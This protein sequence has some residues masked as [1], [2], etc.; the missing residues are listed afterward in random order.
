VARIAEAAGLRLV[1]LHGGEPVETVL[2]LLARG[3]RVI[4]A[5]KTT[6]PALLREAEALPAGVGI[7][8]ECG[9]G[10]LPG[11]NAAGWD[12][13]SARPLG[14]RRPFALAGGLTPE[15]AAAAVEAARPSAVDVSSGVEAAPGR[16]SLE[17]TRLLIQHLQAIRITWPTASVFGSLRPKGTPCPVNR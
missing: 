5:L 7:L 11:G 17:K 13:G 6:G 15:N 12:W 16:K 14:A 2:A 8:V 3:F 1:Q 9:K 10:P 4:K